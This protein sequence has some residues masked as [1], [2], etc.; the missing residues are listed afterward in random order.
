MK[1]LI[2]RFLFIIL[3]LFTSCSENRTYYDADWKK[4]NKENASYYRDPPKEAKGLWGINDY[5]ISGEKQFIGQAKDSL[6]TVL[7]G[8]VTWYFKT[9]KAE[10]KIRYKNGKIIGYYTTLEGA[11]GSSKVGWDENDL[12]FMDYS[13]AAPETVAEA[14]WNNTTVYDYYYADT[15]IVA[16]Q[17]TSNT[18]HDDKF[19]FS[20]FF[21][22]KGDTIGRL[23][24]N[25]KSDKWNGKEVNFYE[26]E[27]VGKN[28]M[29]SIKE[30][31][32][33]SKGCITHTQ[34]YNT[35]EKLIAEGFFKDMKPFKGTFFKEI[36]GFN[37]IQ[38]YK[39]GYLQ[40]ETAY[41]SDDEI[42]GEISFKNKVPNTGVYYNC[43]S[44]QT[45]KNGA[46][47]GKSVQ[48]LYD[49]SE[50]V[51]FEF[52]YK[53]GVEEGDYSI[54]EDESLLLEKGSYKKGVQNGEVTYYHNGDHSGDEFNNNYYLKANI[55]TKNNKP[56]IKRLLQFN[57]DNNEL[58]N[59]VEFEHNTT[60]KFTYINNGYHAI[61][62]KDFNS[63]GFD[64]L[65]ITYNHHRHDIIT[66][67]YY[68]FNSQTNKYEHISEL[69]NAGDVAINAS[70]KTI[71]ASFR[72]KFEDYTTYKTY[73]FLNKKLIK[74]LVVEKV[75]HQRIDTTLVTQTFPLQLEK[76]PLL[77]D[78]LPSLNFIQQ[79][80]VQQITKPYQE[81]VLKK[82]P[83]S[84]T[85]PGLLDNEDIFGFKVKI[86][87]SYNK[88]IFKKAIVNKRE[89]DTSIFR[90]GTTF[91]MGANEPLILD[92]DG[93]NIFYYDDTSDDNLVYLKNINEQVLLLEFN[94][95]KLQDE[96]KNFAISNIK[97][98][99][100]MIIY[101]DK[102][103]NLKIDKNEIHYISLLFQ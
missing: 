57:L 11:E 18:G 49:G 9:G 5:Y 101:M 48:Y 7:E 26:L 103:N 76:Y 17:H 31:N 15:S 90:T 35:S 96:N 28:E 82:E 100:Y 25:E 34:Y 38:Q 71:K 16:S 13:N 69:D 55:K 29:S 84:I 43:S 46:L 32:T 40:K 91:A 65:Q 45:Y 63:D 10:N 58:L 24:K 19:S 97:K 94:I 54:Y 52:M 92:G 85:F 42:I 20:L 77:A 78:N 3:I 51:E 87:A 60:D 80:K 8:D 1:Y 75:Y 83:F 67:T 4:T 14:V 72:K 66:N 33:Y 47:H 93:H 56:F 95:D 70:E 23:D 86:T 99:I 37:K 27:Q 22:K 21:N 44:L 41:N 89:E 64:D 62:F 53:K 36:C 79:N 81:I 59:T 12:Y 39:N 88:E 61:Y 68:L 73:D 74:K 50:S 2:L 102:N 98:P 30:I 6:G